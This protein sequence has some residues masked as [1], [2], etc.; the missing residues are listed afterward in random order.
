MSYIS[1]AGFTPELTIVKVHIRHTNLVPEIEVK[2]VFLESLFQA[3]AT[4]PAG[5]GSE[6]G[7]RRECIYINKRPGAA[8]GNRG[9]P[10]AYPIVAKPGRFAALC[11]YIYN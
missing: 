3:A 11:V 2:V 8:C 6:I 7:A 10:A 5:R 9:V 4:D 1:S